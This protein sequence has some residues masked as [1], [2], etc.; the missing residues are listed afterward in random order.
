M[1]AGRSQTELSFQILSPGMWPLLYERR[2]PE[3]CRKGESV[4]TSRKLSTVKPTGPFASFA[5]EL[6][7]QSGI[8]LMSYLSDTAL[9]KEIRLKG[10]VD[11]VTRADHEVEALIAR[12]IKE[13][14]PS[15]GLLA[16]EGT[17]FAGDEYRW[18][19]DP[20]DGTVNFAHGVP[21]FAVSIALEHRSQVVL[22]V[23][24]HPVLGETFTAE[25][26][27]G[28]WLSTGKGPF[29]RVTVSGAGA[30]PAAVLGTGFA[31]GRLTARDAALVL[32]FIR[33]ARGVRNLGSAAI[34]LAY[35][36]AGRIDAYWEPG[37]NPWDFSAGVLLVEEAGGRVTDTDGAPLRSGD[38]LASNGRIHD[39]ML[40]VIAT[41]EVG[42]EPNEGP[43]SARRAR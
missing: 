32:Q 24:D 27:G 20:L 25:R 12:R 26:G 38:V 41:T 14:F 39:A 36:A 2:E 31:G 30:L 22:G 4:I 8:H 11:V 10:P 23:V 18:V 43:R 5:I 40:E 33:T 35:V 3:L 1:H 37:L 13:S 34:H 16:E 15:H 28:A 42:T 6:A 7:R 9:E 17:L 19:V 29:R 21:W